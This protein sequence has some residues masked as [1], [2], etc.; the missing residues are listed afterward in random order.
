MGKR[1]VKV[2][3]V[4]QIILCLVAYFSMSIHFDNDDL[5]FKMLE[6]TDFLGTFLR[7]SLYLIPG[8]HLLSG[9]YGLVFNDKKILIGMSIVELINS[10]LMFI[11]IGRSEYMLILAIVASVIAVLYFIGVLTTKYNY[12]KK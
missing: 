4:L 5:V 6:N 8:L 9:L 2:M 10:G 11:F 1:I 7:L 12:N 3:S